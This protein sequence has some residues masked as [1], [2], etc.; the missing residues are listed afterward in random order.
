MECPTGLLSS[1]H[2]QPSRHIGCYC[3]LA[4]PVLLKAKSLKKQDPYIPYCHIRH[5]GRRE[6]T[7]LQHNHRVQAALLIQMTAHI[8]ARAKTAAR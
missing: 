4:R 6:A 8:R 5:S 2:R 1:I 7:M 3:I